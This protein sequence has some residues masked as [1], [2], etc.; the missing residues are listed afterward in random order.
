MI[1]INEENVRISHGHSASVIETERKHK[2]NNIT[3]SDEIR[4]KLQRRQLE[5]IN[6]INKSRWFTKN[7]TS[8]DYVVKYIKIKEMSKNTLH[9]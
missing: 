4:E 3:W 2:P 5:M 6:K 9:L 8:M 1:Q 7:D